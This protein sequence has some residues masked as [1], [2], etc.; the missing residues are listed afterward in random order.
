MKTLLL[1]IASLPL[2]A[3]TPPLN[4][5]A[6]T[7]N[8]PVGVYS[9]LW[10]GATSYPL[11][12]VIGPTLKLSTVN[13]RAQLDA[14]IPPAPIV[15]T[16][17]GA[18]MATQLGDFAVTRK[19]PKTLLVGAGLSIATPGNVSQQ[20]AVAQFATAGQITAV[21]GEGICRV[22][23]DGAVSPPVIRAV[24]NGTLAITCS[25]V[26]CSPNTGVSFPPDSRPLAS[27]T[28]SA[29]SWDAQGGVDYR[30]FINLVRFVG[31][32]GIA[33]TSLNGTVTISLDP[34]Q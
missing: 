25:T 6:G 13:G 23:L 31:G 17:G 11:C 14:V 2:F 27:W 19:D 12:A 24:T 28:A 7:C 18:S 30:A 20:E 4:F 32:P 22:F 15:T 26:S 8:F 33:V 1:A 3:Q 5:L 10:T 9:I 21:S 29:G 34:N 16:S